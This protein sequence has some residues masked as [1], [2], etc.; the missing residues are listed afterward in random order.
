LIHWDMS[1]ML[2]SESEMYAQHYKD[3]QD[4][5]KNKV[6]VPY[7]EEDGIFN[8]AGISEFVSNAG[9]AMGTYAAFA[10]ELLVDTA[11]TVLTAGGGA[12]TFGGTIAKV[13]AKSGLKSGAKSGL[14][15]IDDFF[16]GAFKV[17]HM[18]DIA[19][20]TTKAASEVDNMAKAGKNL[21]NMTNASKAIIGDGFDML[22]YNIR[23]II[24]SKSA[25]E[26]FLN[27]GK[28]TPLIGSGVRQAERIVKAGKAGYSTATMVGMGVRGVQR[29]ANEFNM[30][31]TESVFEAISA[32]G[33]T[34]DFM[35]KEYHNRHG[36]GPNG[37][38]FSLMQ[39]HA[40]KAAMANYRTNLVI[41]LA[42]N[43]IQ[44]GT[45]FN[46]FP[47][48]KSWLTRQIIN[49]AGEGIV[50][51]TGKKGVLKVFDTKKFLG[52]IKTVAK[53]GKEFGWKKASWEAA[54]LFR[55]DFLK[56]E[57]TEGLQEIIQE[58]SNIAWKNY[59]A[60]QYTGAEKTITDAFGEGLG[61]QWS[62]Q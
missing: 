40:L 37:L 7:G 27:V 39:D 23:N 51:V 36:E 42:T 15:Y 12:G 46:K 57:V 38:D 49:E 48:H 20:I 24:K 32:Y 47:M 14:N 1:K 26:F 34:L 29:M 21:T 53:I 58:S 28:G 13:G 54:K 3:Q 30:S 4:M 22:T 8:K 55:K 17:G 16:K 60:A 6:F 11:I 18:D 59:Y 9:F 31:S 56:F 5:F 52:G 35:L 45:L 33:E 25:G 10:T 50:G 19:K 41:L 43:K 44:F 2:P 62:K 61:E